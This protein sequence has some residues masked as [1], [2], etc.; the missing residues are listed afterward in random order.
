MVVVGD[1]NS[2]ADGLGTP[3][4]AN[5]VAAGLEDAWNGDGGLHLLARIEPAQPDDG[6]RQ[7]H[8]LRPHPRT[9]AV[10]RAGVVGEEPWN[11]TASG[12]WPS[13]HAGVVATLRVKN[14]D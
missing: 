7:A 13:D 8:R 2:R 3:S 1:L 10:L 6:V 9:G 14:S 5:L 4:Y 11:R 12:L